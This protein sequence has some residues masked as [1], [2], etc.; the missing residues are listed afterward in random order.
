MSNELSPTQKQRIL[1]LVLC[2]DDRRMTV[3]CKTLNV[4]E[5]DVS[6]TI[7]EHNSKKIV[8]ERGNFLVFHSSINDNL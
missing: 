4:S 3:I 2:S 1:E 6:I 8:F 5:T 7:Q